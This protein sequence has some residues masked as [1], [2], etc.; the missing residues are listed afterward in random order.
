MTFGANFTIDEA[1]NNDDQEIPGRQTIH[2]EL[3]DGS[4]SGSIFGGAVVLTFGAGLDLEEGDII[5]L[6]GWVQ[7]ARPLPAF[8]DAPTAQDVAA[9]S[10]VAVEG[11]PKK[12]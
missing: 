6:T 3:T 1:P 8:V 2:A 12:P 10:P 11:S 9:Q 4:A 5:H 7:K